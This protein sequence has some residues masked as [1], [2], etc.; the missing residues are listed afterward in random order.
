M[1]DANDF[2][3]L[4]IINDIKNDE[5]DDD[6]INPKEILKN[7]E[8]YEN[9]IKDKTNKFGNYNLKTD[10]ILENKCIEI[11]KLLKLIGIL[12]NKLRFLITYFLG[13]CLKQHFD[14]K[15]INT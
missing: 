9:I 12:K 1:N 13:F 8:N 11:S 6:I 14:F 3:E 10:K 4:N 15:L 7:I 2:D 5:D